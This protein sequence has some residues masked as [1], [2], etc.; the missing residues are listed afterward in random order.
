MARMVGTDNRGPGG[1]AVPLTPADVSAMDLPVKALTSADR[2]AAARAAMRAWGLSGVG[3]RQADEWTGVLL[4]APPTGVPLTH[5]LAAGGI[6]D[7]TAGLILVYLDPTAPQ[8]G[9]GRRLCVGLSKRLRGQ[10]T[11]IEA[12]GST[13][14][15]TASSLAPSPEWLSKMGFQPVRYPLHRYRLDFASMVAW[16]QKHFQF[17][18]VPAINLSGQPASMRAQLRARQ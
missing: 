8:V 17:Y 5:P 10:V 14:R 3:V 13:S 16:M 9:T 1:L 11:G 15:L 7:E 4:V 2:D 12:Q 6:G 18:F